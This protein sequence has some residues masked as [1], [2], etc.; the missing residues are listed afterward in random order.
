MRCGTGGVGLWYNMVPIKGIVQM[1]KKS[2]LGEFLGTFVLTLFGCACVACAVLFGEYSGVFQV[3]VPSA[4]M[5]LLSVT[6]MTVLNNFTASYGA[7][8]VA[9]MEVEDFPAIVV[10]DATGDNYYE[11]GQAPY[12]EI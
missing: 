8:A 1:D 7:E 6:G 2:F 11:T 5:N 10:I 3:G 9:A 12:R 4:V